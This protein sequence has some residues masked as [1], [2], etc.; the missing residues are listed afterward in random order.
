MKP[1]AVKWLASRIRE[2]MKQ[3][4]YIQQDVATVDDDGDVTELIMGSL[5]EAY[6]GLEMAAGDLRAYLAA[7]AE[8]KDE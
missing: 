2:E 7:G 5:D 1:A 8:G 3:I 4:D 6:T